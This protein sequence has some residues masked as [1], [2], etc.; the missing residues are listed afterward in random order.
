MRGS[1]LGPSFTYVFDCG[2]SPST[3]RVYGSATSA[4]G[5]LDGFAY[6]YVMKFFDQTNTAVPILAG[7]DAPQFGNN[8]PIELRQ[9][10]ANSVALLLTGLS[11]ATWNGAPLPLALGSIGAPGC[12]LL[13]AFDAGEVV[14][15]DGAGR[16]STDVLVPVNFALLGVPFYNQYAV[17]DPA[18]NG[19]GFAFSNGGVGVIGN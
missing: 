6:G 5:S 7:T 9:A 12:S 1:Q 13:A 2:W 3:A 18:A 16:G 19:F 14:L 8:V 11:N 15:T 10:K 17:Y 4:T